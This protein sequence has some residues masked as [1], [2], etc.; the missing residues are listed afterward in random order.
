MPEPVE[1]KAEE[2]EEAVSE[3]VEESPATTPEPVPADA[4][5]AVEEMKP[6]ESPT[7]ETTEAPASEEP[8]ATEEPAAP[9]ETS[10]TAPAEAPAAEEKAAA[11][12]R[13]SEPVIGAV[14]AG[15]A[16]VVDGSDAMALKNF[17]VN[18]LVIAVGD[19]RA[20][21]LAADVP[22]LDRT[23]H[24]AVMEKLAAAGSP[25]ASGAMMPGATGANTG[26]RNGILKGPLIEVMFGRFE[27]AAFDAM[28]DACV[29]AVLSAESSMK[30]AE[31]L[32]GETEA[33]AFQATVEG[34]SA[35][36]DST[37]GVMLVQ[38]HAGAPIG[39]LVNYAI[40]PPKSFGENP[41]NGR[42]VPGRIAEALRAR[43][44]PE[45]PV[46]FYNGASEDLATNFGDT[47][48]ARAAAFDQIAGLAMDALKGATG[49]RES[50]LSIATWEAAMP[51]TLLGEIL[52]S[53]TLLTE[54]MLSSDRFVSMPGLPAAQIGMLLRVK[55]LAMGDGQLFLCSGT[56]DFQGVHPGVNEF[57]SDS[58]RALMAFQGPLMIKWY[59]D[60][61]V[62]GE[63]AEEPWRMVPELADRAAAF[64][65][66]LA[67]AEERK[68]ELE[69]AWAK[70]EE[71]LAKLARILV[72]MK[73]QLK[74]DI[75]PEIDALI[76]A[77]S[78]EQVP[79]V[80]RQAAAAYL[81]SQVAG[82]T[83]DERT[84]LMGYSDAL[85][86]PFDGLMLMDLLGSPD[87]LPQQVQGI[88]V[89]V[90]VS[91]HKVLN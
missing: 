36:L 76:G 56:N 3:M 12:P 72:S 62:L 40:V 52:P 21:F 64:E 69:A 25:V 50:S 41:L 73:G 14:S 43:I 8:S 7:A 53:S 57:F 89:L 31:Y 10:A 68:A 60:N 38:D 67:A 54:V 33:P 17:E 39:A 83:P 85:G 23:L 29:Q 13:R 58:E 46:V 84:K 18:A 66:G 81:R 26:W 86:I 30:P 63:S 27:Q 11:A 37:L 70:Q 90:Q 75:P 47:P 9:A 5:T 55:S 87:K 1:Q 22:A 34:G 16:R 20:A 88:L 35:T 48:E 19:A 74:G 59:G 91:G 2:T 77:L 24:D 42:G 4:E 44:A 65:A 71:S 61:L 79:L 6:A 82:Y 45:L 78:P 80:G 15:A 28:A 32:M 49:K 51:P